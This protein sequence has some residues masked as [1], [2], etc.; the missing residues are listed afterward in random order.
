MEEPVYKAEIETQVE[1]K[2]MDTQG[3]NGGEKN[4][5]TGTDIY[6]TDIVYKTDD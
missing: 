3:G 1:N 4:W 6:T 5:E 2:C